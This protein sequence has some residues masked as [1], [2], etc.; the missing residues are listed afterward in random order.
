[1][2]VCRKCV[3]DLNKITGKCDLY[4][5]VCVCV[6]V[7]VCVWRVGGVCL[8]CHDDVT[9]WKNIMNPCAGIHRSR[10]SDVEGVLH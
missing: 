8:S 9:T 10:A 1:M 4:M 3:F 7:C 5:Y 2:Y 6:C